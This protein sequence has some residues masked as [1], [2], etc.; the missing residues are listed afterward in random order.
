MARKGPTL[1]S[2]GRLIEKEGTLITNSFEN[3]D[4]K[5]C[6]RMLEIESIKVNN[7]FKRKEMF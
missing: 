1:S 2:E 5:E 6:Q 3:D 7:L 4:I